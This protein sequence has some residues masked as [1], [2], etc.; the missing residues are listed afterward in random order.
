MKAYDEGNARRR[1]STM[2]RNIHLLMKRGALCGAVL[3]LLT[4]HLPAQSAE[5]LRLTVGRSVIIEYPSD[6]ATID[7]GNPDIA[8][9]VVRTT[10]EVLINPKSIGNTTLVIW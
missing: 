10:R 8:D 1:N 4:A 9:V 7:T 3:T 5:A 2:I 6:I